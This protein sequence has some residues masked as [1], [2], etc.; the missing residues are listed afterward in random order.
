MHTAA[1]RFT[2]LIC[3]LGLS[4]PAAAQLSERPLPSTRPIGIVYPSEVGRTTTNTQQDDDLAFKVVAEVEQ[5]LRKLGYQVVPRAEV[6]QKL[7][8]AGV[9]CAAGVQN[10][11]SSDVLRS[12]DLGAVVLVAIWWDQRPADITIEVTTADATGI[13]KSKLDADVSRQVPELVNSALRDLKNGKAVDV[14]IYS[15]PIGA[16]VRLDSDLIGI[17]PVNAK[18][19]PGPHEVIVSYPD[20]VTTSRHFDVPRGADGPV[21]VDVTLERTTASAAQAAD[22]PMP[23]PTRATPTWDYALGSGLAVAGAVLVISPIMT[24][25]RNGDCKDGSNAVGC[26]RVHFGS[27]S[28]LLMASGLL[29]LSGSVLLF[30]TTPIR[31]SLSTDGEAIHAQLHATF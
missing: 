20:Y 10:C 16:E 5:T 4:V 21:R 26:E 18:A 12:L 24:L 22:V 23:P 8:D 11:P 17:A 14:G 9:N 19:G 30:A 28:G 13:A 2:S 31:A 1:Y 6:V 27:R 7:V 15:V 3:L 25:A 29:A